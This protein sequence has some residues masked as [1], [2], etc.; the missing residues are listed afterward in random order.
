[1]KSKTRLLP[2]LILPVLLF[3]SCEF[4]A[5]RQTEEKNTSIYNLDV[6]KDGAEIELA[7]VGSIKLRFSKDKGYVPYVTLKQY[8]SFFKPRFDE[9]VESVVS[10]RGSVLVWTVTKDSELYYISQIDLSNKQVMSAGNLEAAFKAG[11]DTRDTKS[12]Y[13]ASTTNYTSERL[14]KNMYATYSFENLDIDYFTFLNEYFLPLGFFDIT[15]SFDAGIY[16]HYNYAHLYCTRDVT[17]FSAKA[18]KRDGK[19]LTVD[20]EMANSKSDTL[21]PEYLRNYNA[22]LFLYLLD[23][24]YG[25]KKY[26]QI[27]SA[28]DFC[29]NMGTYDKLFSVDDAIRVQAYADTLALLDDNHTALVSANNAWGEQTFNMR[30]YGDNCFN[31]SRA[32]TQLIQ[33]RTASTSAAYRNSEEIVYSVDGKTAMFLFD[34][35][36]YGTSSQVFNKD[37]SIKEDA[38]KYDSFIYLINKFK[39]IE[40]RGGVENIVLDMSTNGGGVLG[41]LMKLSAL[42]SKGNNGYLYYH[43]AMTDQVGIAYTKVDINQ[44]GV[45]NTDDCYGDDFNIYLLTSDCSYSCGNAFPCMAQLLGDAKIIGEKSGGGECAVGI[46][47]L[48][49]SEY[50]YHSSNL[51]IGFYDEENKVFTGFEDGVTPDIPISSYADFFNINTLAVYIENSQN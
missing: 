29:K 20:T 22:N 28:V 11:D 51:H 8:A 15:Y 47:Y 27:E 31:R 25:L 6:I 5:S 16:F 19:T 7:K 1:M 34:N 23:N 43:E 9:G 32:R 49:N 14:S 45:Y 35:F 39:E 26:K 21:M 42:I 48:P 38:G 2:L 33:S 37:G 13:Y 46:H 10:K 24:F 4:L 50:V 18:F 30:Q 41:V 12:L 36:V 40:Q 44:D 17:N 3:S